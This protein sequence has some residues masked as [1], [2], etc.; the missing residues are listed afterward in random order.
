[1]P[2]TFSPTL[3]RST[4]LCRYVLLLTECKLRTIDTEKGGMAARLTK[5]Y[6]QHAPTLCALLLLS[7]SLWTYSVVTS[8][9]GLLL[10]TTAL[11]VASGLV[12]TLLSSA[13]SQLVQQD[14]VGGAMGISAAIGSLSR[15]VAPPVGG[16]F[17]ERFGAGQHAALASVLVAVAAL[18][19][20]FN[21]KVEEKHQPK[22]KEVKVDKQKSEEKSPRQAKKAEDILGEKSPRSPRKRARRSSK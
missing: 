3:P 12:Q 22:K 4:L 13:I 20:P 17:T 6:G 8:L 18:L 9:T 15:V 11:A 5:R 19:A 1:M 21:L 2:V 7:A 10:S 14:E 16:Q